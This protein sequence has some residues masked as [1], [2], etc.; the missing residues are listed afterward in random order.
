MKKHTTLKA[1][2]DNPPAEV[3]KLK[4]YIPERLEV[5]QKEIEEDTQQLLELEQKLEQARVHIFTFKYDILVVF[6]DS[7]GE[8]A[9]KGSSRCPCSS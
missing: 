7:E 9:Q 1:K 2:S 6:S 5:R 4:K 3:A 8:R